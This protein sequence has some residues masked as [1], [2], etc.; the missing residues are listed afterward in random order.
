MPKEAAKI[1][2][3]KICK[4]P[5]R[6]VRVNRGTDGELEA[7]SRMVI[8]GDEL[9]GDQTI[10]RDAP[11]APQVAMYMLFSDAVQQ[12]WQASLFDVQDAFLVNERDIYIKP[13]REGIPGVPPRALLNSREEHLDF[14]KHLAYGG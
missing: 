12:G 11:V 1:P 13:P 9:R 5:A 7:K 2:A 14:L 3:S 6:Y 10:R 8:P 4:A